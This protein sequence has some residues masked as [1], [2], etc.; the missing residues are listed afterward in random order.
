VPLAG[1][2]GISMGAPNKISPDKRNQEINSHIMSSTGQIE[3]LKDTARKIQ[4]AQIESLKAQGASDSSTDSSITLTK[5]AT[6]L[7]KNRRRQTASTSVRNCLSQ[8]C[9]VAVSQFDPGEW[10]PPDKIS[11]G[12][13]MLWRMVCEVMGCPWNQSTMHCCSI[14]M[15]PLT[16]RTSVSLRTTC[17]VINWLDALNRD[18]RGQKI[19]CFT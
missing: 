15:E 7:S 19:Q 8:V 5:V 10:T 17:Q 16:M 1:D 4:I 9:M 11:P 14:W 12:A 13:L 3:T 2:F 18:S 6:S